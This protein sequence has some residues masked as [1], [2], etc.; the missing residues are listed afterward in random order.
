ME[1]HYLL[2]Y[3]NGTGHFDCA[4]RH[5]TLEEAIEA[6][7][8]GWKPRQYTTRGQDEVVWRNYEVL[9]DTSYFES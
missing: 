3:D 6:A 1:D 9:P 2:W 5:S 8:T 7:K 4:S